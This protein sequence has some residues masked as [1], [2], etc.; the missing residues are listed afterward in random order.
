MGPGV[1]SKTGFYR[2]EVDYKKS[3]SGLNQTHRAVC[4]QGPQLDRKL[5]KRPHSTSSWGGLFPG[6][7]LILTIIKPDKRGRKKRSQ[8]G[9]LLGGSKREKPGALGAARGSA[10]GGAQAEKFRG[11]AGPGAFLL[12]NLLAPLPL[13][14][15]SSPSASAHV[16]VSLMAP[17][18][19]KASAGRPPRPRPRPRAPVLA[20]GARSPP[21]LTSALSPQRGTLTRGSSSSILNGERRGPWPPP[22]SKDGAGAGTERA[23]P[24]SAR[25]QPKHGPP[26]LRAGGRAGASQ[27]EPRCPPR[28]PPPPRRAEMRNQQNLASEG[29]ALPRLTERDS[30]SPHQPRPL[31]QL[32]QSAASGSGLPARGGVVASGAWAGESAW[33]CAG[34]DLLVLGAV[35]AQWMAGS[36][37]ERCD[38]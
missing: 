21:P 11:A 9:S 22:R 8:R 28:P 26:L 30:T 37:C 31:P 5:L 3:Q 19:G 32:S 6:G 18:G 15:A 36:M 13:P 20:S 34:Y 27:C 10:L 24:S 16:P 25:G 2:G 7:N 14:R 4:L 12:P 35:P 38:F 33:S 29:F 23:R 1:I 17:P